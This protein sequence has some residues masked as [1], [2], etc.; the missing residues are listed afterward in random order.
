[1]MPIYLSYLQFQIIRVFLFCDQKIK[2]A[3]R[4]HPQALQEKGARKREKCGRIC[5]DWSSSFFPC[6]HN[7]ILRQSVPQEYTFCQGIHTGSIHCLV[8]GMFLNALSFLL[9]NSSTVI[10]NSFQK[11]AQHS[12]QP[13][14][15]FVYFNIETPIK[16][17]CMPRDRDEKKGSKYL[18]EQGFCRLSL[19]LCKLKLSSQPCKARKHQYQ[20]IRLRLG[21]D[22]LQSNPMGRAFVW[23]KQ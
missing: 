18:W 10:A 21:R 11:T 16:C 20:N 1:M 5:R 14:F 22:M 23:T 15:N 8:L 4:D 17:S 6:Q 3:V 12:L 9:A 13:C 19:S 2:Q 7:E